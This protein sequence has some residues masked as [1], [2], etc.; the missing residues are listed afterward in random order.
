MKPDK[1]EANNSYYSVVA[2]LLHYS[3]LLSGLRSEQEAVIT[4]CALRRDVVIGVHGKNQSSDI[5]LHLALMKDY[6]DQVYKSTM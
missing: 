5:V 3:V 2:C 6:T 1:K 4:Q